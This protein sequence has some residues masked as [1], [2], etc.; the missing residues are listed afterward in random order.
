MKV[1]TGCEDSS[2]AHPWAKLSDDCVLSGL[3]H[4]EVQTLASH[5]ASRTVDDEE[6]YTLLRRVC[7]VQVFELYKEIDGAEDGNDLG[8]LEKLKLS[9]ELLTTVLVRATR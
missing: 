3:S 7:V 9:V 6:V 4:S 1:L 2:H 5:L 8:R